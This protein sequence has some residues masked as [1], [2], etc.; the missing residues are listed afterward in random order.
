M[1]DQINSRMKLYFGFAM[2]RRPN[3]IQSAQCTLRNGPWKEVLQ[4]SFFRKQRIPLQISNAI[5][6]AYK[7]GKA[8]CWTQLYTDGTRAVV[9]YHSRILNLI[10]DVKYDGS[11]DTVIVRR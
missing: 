6:A 7:L 11:T 2:G 1:V 4:E 8:K 5:L 10:A 9:N 3:I